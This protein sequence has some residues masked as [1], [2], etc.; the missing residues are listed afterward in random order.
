MMFMSLC[1]ELTICLSVLSIPRRRSEQVISTENVTKARK[2]SSMKRFLLS[3][4][5]FFGSSSEDV[6]KTRK[7]TSPCLPPVDVTT[8]KSSFIETRPL[9]LRRS[10]LHPPSL[11]PSATNSLASQIKLAWTERRHLLTRGGVAVALSRALGKQW[12]R[13]QLCSPANTSLLQQ[14]ALGILPLRR[15]NKN[16]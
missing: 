1:N 3:F 10:S 7:E 12:N 16:K 5:L 15:N 11:S 2:T 9:I 14:I 4:T 8:L 6:G 13:L